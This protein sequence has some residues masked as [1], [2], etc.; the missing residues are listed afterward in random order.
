[1]RPVETL[2]YFFVGRMPPSPYDALR[3]GLAPPV[4]FSSEGFPSAVAPASESFPDEGC[5]HSATDQNSCVSATTFATSI[6]SFFSEAA[7]TFSLG[8]KRL[9]AKRRL[10]DE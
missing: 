5:F 2:P 10:P 9:R 6:R 7:V 1:M 8:R 3:I 4:D